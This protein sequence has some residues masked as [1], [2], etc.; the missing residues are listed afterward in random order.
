MSALA[1]RGANVGSTPIARQ[2]Q[3]ANHQVAHHLVALGIAFRAAVARPGDVLTQLRQDLL[4]LVMN[5]R[6]L[7]A[8]SFLSSGSTSY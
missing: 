4:A 7:L 1:L 8:T 5:A 6:D 3:N 2:R